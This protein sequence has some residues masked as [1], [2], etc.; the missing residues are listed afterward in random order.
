MPDIDKLKRRAAAI[1]NQAANASNEHEKNVFQAKAFALMA[2][3]GLSEAELRAMKAD[4]GK[5]VVRHI[6]FD[7]KYPVAQCHLMHALAHALHCESTHKTSYAKGTVYGV[8]S[9]VQRVEILFELLRPQLLKEMS[10]TRPDPSDYWSW[11]SMSA[12]EKAAE[13]REHRRGFGQGF[14]NAI[15]GRLAIAE[16]DV[17]RAA[18][19]AAA[20]RN[21]S[22]GAALMLLSDHE[23]AQKEL[24]TVLGGRKLKSAKYKEAGAGYY[25]GRAA[26][27]RADIAGDRTLK[28]KIAIG[29]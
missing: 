17:I 3:Y 1:L 22:S 18:E 5:V 4:P 7:G 10:A 29:A 24:D 12:G 2:E 14:A 9:H 15:Y 27:T 26:G 19:E 28:N 13:V 25:E 11:T 6:R 20:E 23:K 21:E 8:E 16:A